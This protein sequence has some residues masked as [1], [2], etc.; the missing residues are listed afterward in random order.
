M[1]GK[2]LSDG[3]VPGEEVVEGLLVLS[4]LLVVGLGGDVPDGFGGCCCPCWTGSGDRCGGCLPFGGD[5]GQRESAGGGGEERTTG[6]RGGS[7]CSS[8]GHFCSEDSGVPSKGGLSGTVDSWHARGVGLNSR[9]GR[10]VCEALAM[11]IDGMGA[12]TGGLDG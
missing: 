1:D 10:G 9:G 8:G 12:A 6:Q 3:K 4:L 11:L 7:G 2:A 5:A